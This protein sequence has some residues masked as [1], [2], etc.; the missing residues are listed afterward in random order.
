MLNVVV[1]L[2][3]WGGALRDSKVIIHSDTAAVVS[4]LNLY[5]TKDD[6]L[7]AVLRNIW[8]ITASFNIN[9]ESV[10]VLGKENCIA[11][12]LSRW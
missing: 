7:V 2:R 10:H 11:D 9:V 1:S 4:I 8:L 6:F 5:K 3:V 12:I